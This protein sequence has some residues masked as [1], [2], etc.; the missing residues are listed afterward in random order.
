MG[1]VA[2]IGNHTAGI[3][4]QS[5]KGGQVGQS[6]RSMYQDLGIEIQSESSTSNSLT[7]RLEAGQ[8]TKYTYARFFWIQ[9]RA[10][11]GDLSV[12]KVLTVKNCADVGTQ[13]VSASILQQRCKFAGWYSSDHGSHTP[14]QDDGDGPM[15][16]LVT[17][18]QTRRHEHRP[19]EESTG[20]LEVDRER[21]DRCAKL[22]ETGERWTSLARLTMNGS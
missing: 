5:L 15:M 4:L 19:K 22:S 1:R 7:D 3:C 8:R 10:Q 13:P 2:Q 11:D 6:L 20:K 21:R 9:E 14:L 18:L 17:G 12:K 16:Y